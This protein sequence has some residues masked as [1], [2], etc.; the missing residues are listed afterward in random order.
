M[1]TVMEVVKDRKSVKAKFVP[2]RETL[3]HF[4]SLPDVFSKAF[5][6]VQAGPVCISGWLQNI[7]GFQRIAKFLFSDDVQF[8]SFS[9]RSFNQDPVENFFSRIRQVLGSNRNPTCNQFTS[10]FKSVLLAT[11]SEPVKID[12]TCEDDDDLL[13]NL[14]EFIDLCCSEKP[15]EEEVYD[16]P[17]LIRELSPEMAE[18]SKFSKSRA[19]LTKVRRQSPATLCS[20][21]IQSFLKNKQYSECSTCKE[22]LST[23]T[24]SSDHTL[25]RSLLYASP[26]LISFYMKTEKKF[27]DQ[28]HNYLHKSDV[29]Q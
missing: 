13:L 20:K 21:L 11:L 22:S 8:T 14:N 23:D 28:C 16:R 5:S 18:L 29:H 15:K 10:A 6:Y 17:V 1:C 4:F 24:L 26:H 9:L 12:K 25:G 2:M 27:L 3:N 19:Y 7:K